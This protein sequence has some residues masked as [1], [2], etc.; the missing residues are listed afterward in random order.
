MRLYG[1]NPVLERLKNN[2]KSIVKL[3]LQDGH[4]DAGYV[5]KKARKWGIPVHNMPKHKMDKISRNLNAQGVMAEIGE[6]PYIEFDELLDKALS[7]KICP[8]F[9]DGLTDPQNLGSIMRSLACLDGF[10]VILPTH[11]SVSI[12]ETV[13][14]IACGG[15]NYV[16]VARVAN[17][18]KAIRESKNRGFSILGAVVGEG[19][20][21]RKAVFDFPVGLVVGS[22]QKG[23]RPVIRKELDRLLT[24]PMPGNR[25]S[26]NAAHAATLFCYEISRHRNNF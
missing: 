14:R 15:E 2:P 16:P 11:E 9:L 20:D 8:V 17:L 5:Y 25:V 21:I 1:K 3:Y 13:L 19:E 12:T 10:A 18:S 22:E 6:F 4:A 7:K 26:L 24:L 23:I